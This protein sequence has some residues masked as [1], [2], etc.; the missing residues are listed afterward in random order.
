MSDEPIEKPAKGKAAEKPVEEFADV[1][2]LKKTQIGSVQAAP[3]AILKRI[4]RKD[5]DLLESRGEGKIIKT[6]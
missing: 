1:K 4:S 5:A 3:G 6:Y 2:V